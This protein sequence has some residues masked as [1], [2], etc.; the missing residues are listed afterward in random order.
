MK[1]CVCG[2]GKTEKYL[3]NEG[4]CVCGEGKQRNIYPMKVCLCGEGKQRNIYPMKVC[5]V[6]RVNREISIQ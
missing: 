1:V 6:E 4:V 3:S 5:G 2:E